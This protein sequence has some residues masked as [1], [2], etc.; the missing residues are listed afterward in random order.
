M[1]SAA[2]EGIRQNLDPGLPITGNAYDVE[3]NLPV[4][5][6]FASNLADAAKA[7]DASSVARSYLGDEFVDHFVM[8]RHWEVREYQRSLN[9]WQLER[10]FEII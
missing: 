2:L 3:D 1:L 6:K 5:A 8:S 10:Y 7:L 9:S 4:E